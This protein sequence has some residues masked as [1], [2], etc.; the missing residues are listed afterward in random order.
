MPHGA[1]SLRTR[2]PSTAVTD[3]APIVESE[4]EL[5]PVLAGVKFMHMERRAGLGPGRRG[6]GSSFLIETERI[7]LEVAE[8]R[9]EFYKM[10]IGMQEAV[11]VTEDQLYNIESVTTCKN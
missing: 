7:H 8:L 1:E 3:A 9:R 6:S 10:Q 5:N 2:T 11:Q 4:R